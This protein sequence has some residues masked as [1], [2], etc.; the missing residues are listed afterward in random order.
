MTSYLSDRIE[1]YFTPKAKEALQALLDLG[2]DKD[3]AVLILE[4]NCEDHEIYSLEEE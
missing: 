2:I 1:G 3:I 4:Q